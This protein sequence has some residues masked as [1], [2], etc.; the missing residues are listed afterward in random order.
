[1]KVY[2]FIDLDQ[3]YLEYFYFYIAYHRLLI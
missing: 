3:A 1:V 2:H